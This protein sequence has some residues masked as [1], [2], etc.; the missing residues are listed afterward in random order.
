[1]YEKIL[2]LLND[3]HAFLIGAIVVLAIGFYGYGCQSTVKSIIDPENKL[4]RA[5]LQTEVD[6]LLSQAQNRFDELDRQDQIKL[7][8]FEQ[9]ALFAQTGTINPMGLL[10][11]AV[12]VVAVG[13]ALDQRRKKKELEQRMG[14]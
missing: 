3:N 5:E 6:Y 4:T 11:T 14:I 2:K 13:S 12:S 9:A 8:I 7:L 10:T 1:M